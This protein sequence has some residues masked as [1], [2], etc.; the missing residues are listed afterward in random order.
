MPRRPVR[1]R[2]EG[3]GSADDDVEPLDPLTLKREPIVQV[4]LPAREVALKVLAAWHDPVNAFTEP[5]R[6]TIAAC[7]AL[8]GAVFALAT[9]RD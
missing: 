1:L 4:R 6:L 9:L 5:I 3:H 8:A 7:A 2:R